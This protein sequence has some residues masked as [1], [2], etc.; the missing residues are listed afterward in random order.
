MQ[1]R[2][3][4]P[5][6]KPESTRQNRN[7]GPRRKTANASSDRTDARWNG[8]ED[9]QIG[10]REANSRIIYGVTKNEEMDLVEGSTTAEM[11]GAADKEGAGHVE[12][13]A[14]PWER[15]TEEFLND[16]VER[17]SREEKFG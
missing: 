4:G 15:G 13:P 16:C 6:T 11:E 9:L 2:H 8:R 5:R 17:N 12:S 10:K 1:Q 14:Q 3:R 7:K